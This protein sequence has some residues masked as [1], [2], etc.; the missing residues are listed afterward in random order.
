MSRFG[1]EVSSDVAQVV[2]AWATLEPFGTLFQT[3]TWLL[4]WFAVIG[5]KFGASPVFVTVRDY[6]TRRPV[7]FFA[8]CRQSRRGLVMIEFPDLNVSD[9]NAPLVD[10]GVT[11]TRDEIAKLWFEICKALPQA[12]VIRFDKIPQKIFGNQ[13]P[14]THLRW[15]QTMDTRSWMLTLPATIDEYENNTL[16]KKV[17]KEQKRKRNRLEAHSGKLTFYVADTYNER[18]KIFN[19]LK[20]QRRAR[21]GV[22][23]ILQ[24]PT[25]SAFY[26]AIGVNTESAMFTLSALKAGDAIV[27]T[28]LSL[29]SGDYC[30][31]LF[32]CFEPALE[33]FSPG[34]VALN[35]AIA[36]AIDNGIRYFDFSVGNLAYKQQFG[37]REQILLHGL[38]PLSL[39][40]KLYK[41]AW[42]L[43][44]KWLGSEPIK[45]LA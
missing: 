27:A 9:Y 11:L 6:L 30:C 23:E 18:R 1:V 35:S 15:L 37:V 38:Y 5:P 25:F 41:L 31:V 16:V 3:R 42:K 40:G 28:L 10:P 4:S 19:A 20:S 39:R 36:W 13:N 43:K 8:L 17:K 44:K 14:I 21:Y 7:M 45:W 26:E 12:D 22:G 2:D 33:A 24:N 34:I 32:H 29:R